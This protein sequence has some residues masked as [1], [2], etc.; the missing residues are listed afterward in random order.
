MNERPWL[1]IPV[2]TKARELE[3]KTYLAC[4][5]ADSGFH[6]LLGEQNAL[7]RRPA[8]LPR[9][10]Y[11]DKALAP[12]KIPPFR[13]LKGLGYRVVAWCE[14]GLVYRDRDAYLRERIAP[15]AFDE[16]D[17]FFAW[18][19]TQAADVRS[20]VS[21]VPAR[22]FETGNPRFDLLRPG[23]R[24][25]YRPQAEALHARHGDFILVNTNFARYNHYFGRERLFDML[26]TRGLMKNPKDEAFFRDWG[27]FLGRVFHSFEEMLAR[28]AAAVP[29]RKIVLRPHPSEN[30][31]TWRGI[32]AGIPNVEV[33]YEGS[34]IPWL[35]ASKLSIH[36]SC[37][38]G[39]E[40]ALLDK[41]VIAYRKVRSET[42]DSFLPNR[43]S[44]N[45]D[46]FDELAAA[47]ESV[48]SGSYR[49]PI[50]GDAVVR[51]DVERYIAPL[52][53]PQASDQIVAKISEL[54]SSHPATVRRVS[55]ASLLDQG[56]QAA[57]FV[58]RT[59]L[60][61][62]RATGGYAKQKFPGLSHAELESLMQQFRR[63]TGRFGA[64]VPR[65]VSENIFVFR[66]SDFSE[67]R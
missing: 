38:T 42:F 56:E 63:I 8:L 1:I 66:S 12:L 22:I 33:I 29:A 43:V 13:R 48:F 64:I 23:L 17:A 4:V 51:A 44:V 30:H 9:G 54:A 61:P 18:G 53:G 5:A 65:P 7:L 35:L 31:E 46:T 62:F 50:A 21:N 26:K 27:D 32:A 11:I 3:A 2:E 19:P 49:A 45:A 58:A 67:E 16:I 59:M 20:V 47:V 6:V 39:L 14:E 60:A 36:N 41:P 25:L 28:L 24:E 34:A 15:K 40:G 10:F 52:E 37:T 55:I 57:R